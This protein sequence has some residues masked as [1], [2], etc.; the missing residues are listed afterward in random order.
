MQ[1]FD[2]AAPVRF[3]IRLSAAAI[4]HPAIFDHR[5][6]EAGAGG[7]REPFRSLTVVTQ[8]ADAVAVMQRQVIHG[9]RMPLL[10]TAPEQIER[11]GRA[12]VHLIEHSE[13][14]QRADIAA[15][16]RG[17][18]VSEP[19]ARQG[20]PALVIADTWTERELLIGPS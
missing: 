6:D 11:V 3:R 17:V 9:Q 18:I 8:Q 4:K 12:A 1:P 5:R 13:V 7:P 20:A 14:V 19:G 16:V 2:G 15:T 10:C